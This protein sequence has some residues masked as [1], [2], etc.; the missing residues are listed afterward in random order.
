M[1]STT[2]TVAES[3]E[4]PV[5]AN[6]DRWET[7][8]RELLQSKLEH[9]GEEVLRDAFTDAA[10][11]IATGEQLHEREIQSMRQALERANHVLTLAAQVSPDTTPRPDLWE[12]LDDQAKQQYI[13]DVERHPPSRS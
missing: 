3:D 11:R 9:V 1:S 7:V 2:L 4:L 13:D 8:G 5:P 12:Y 10:W 6:S